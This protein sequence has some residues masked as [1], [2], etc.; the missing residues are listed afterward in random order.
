MTEDDSS[1]EYRTE[2]FC[3]Q[4]GG[5]EDG[6]VE[7]E[8]TELDNKQTDPSLIAT[9]DYRFKFE[10][11]ACGIS[12]TVETGVFPESETENFYSRKVGDDP[13]IRCRIDGT[14]VQFRDIDE[15]VVE[16]TLINHDAVRTSRIRHVHVHAINAPTFS[17]DSAHRVQISGVVDQQMMLGDIRYHDSKHRT[18]KF[19]RGLDDGIIKTVKG[20]N[21]GQDGR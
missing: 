21:G 2:T 18:L 5:D 9:E 8:K 12:A 1:S 3:T 17:T 16:S 6:P 10:C 11:T 13:P 4:C 14:E 20:L 19:F 15:K 7:V